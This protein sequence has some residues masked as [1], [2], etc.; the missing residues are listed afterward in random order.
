MDHHSGK[1]L[2]IKINPFP[3]PF[4]KSNEREKKLTSTSPTLQQ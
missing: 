3:S 2:R 4:H 1:V